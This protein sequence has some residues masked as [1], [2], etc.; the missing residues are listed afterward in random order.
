MLLAACVGSVQSQEVVRCGNKGSYASYPPLSVSRSKS[1]GGDQ[2]YFM[3]YRKLNIHERNNQSIPTNDWWTNMING[4]DHV[5]GNDLTGH[6]WSYPLYV[7]ATDSTL[8]I[9]TTG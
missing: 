5:N 4:D 9:L 2:S 8:S 1:H 6:L 7:H 3:E